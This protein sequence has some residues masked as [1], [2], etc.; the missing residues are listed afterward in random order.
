[1]FGSPVFGSPVFGGGDLAAGSVGGFDG[2]SSWQTTPST[3]ES[4]S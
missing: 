1:M 3:C 4:A 2:V